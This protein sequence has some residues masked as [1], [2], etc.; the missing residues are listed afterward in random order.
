MT[1][2]EL[3]LAV[4][5]ALRGHPVVV[6]GDCGIRSKGTTAKDCH[7]NSQMSP[8]G[9]ICVTRRTVMLETDHWH[10]LS[11]GRHRSLSIP[12]EFAIQLPPPRKG[13]VIV[14]LIEAEGSTPVAREWRYSTDRSFWADVVYSVSACSTSVRSIW[15]QRLDRMQDY[16]EGLATNKEKP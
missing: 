9:G 8:R 15:E 4:F 13:R 1:Q 14:A 10:S 5:W 16:V 3:L 2:S 11:A 6:A 7:G 12:F